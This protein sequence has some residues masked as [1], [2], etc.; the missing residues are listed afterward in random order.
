MQP[1]RNKLSSYSVPT[2]LLLSEICSA[3]SI[4]VVFLTVG[5]SFLFFRW[6]E[7]KVVKYSKNRMSRCIGGQKSGL[8]FLITMTFETMANESYSAMVKWSRYAWS[9]LSYWIR[10]D[11]LCYLYNFIKPFTDTIVLTTVISFEIFV[12]NYFCLDIASAP[13]AIKSWSLC[14]C[15]IRLS[16]K[17][18]PVIGFSF[19]RLQICHLT[20]LCMNSPNFLTDPEISI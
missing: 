12:W 20:I 9:P 7:S 4:L 3:M 10:T 1:C 16:W 13:I 18:T 17:L 5:W 8:F 11:I 15:D 2:C 6:K 19:Y 14:K